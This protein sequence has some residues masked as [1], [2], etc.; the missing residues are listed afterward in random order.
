MVQA[1]SVREAST[2]KRDLDEARHVVASDVY[3]GA[4]VEYLCSTRRERPPDS[5]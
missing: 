4:V 1:E 2:K 5:A 3:R